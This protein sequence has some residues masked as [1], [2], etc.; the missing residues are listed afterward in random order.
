MIAQRAVV[1][2]VL[3]SQ[4]QEGKYSPLRNRLKCFPVFVLS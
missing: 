3:L 2:L 1:A 4:Q